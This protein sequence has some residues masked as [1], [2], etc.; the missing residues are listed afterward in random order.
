MYIMELAHSKEFDPYSFDVKHIPG[1]RYKTNFSEK[2]R[3]AINNNRLK[4]GVLTLNHNF[5]YKNQLFNVFI[6]E[7]GIGETSRKEL[8]QFK[9]NHQEYK[10]YLSERYLIS[11][12]NAEAKKREM[13]R[14]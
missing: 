7:V 2:V 8:A 5:Y 14:S 6:R 13:A 11:L 4:C 9:M 3:M 12:R 10:N 1:S